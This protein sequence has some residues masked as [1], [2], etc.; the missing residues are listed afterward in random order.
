MRPISPNFTIA[1]DPRLLFPVSLPGSSTDTPNNR[2]SFEQD[3]TGSQTHPTVT[4]VAGN[5]HFEQH[6]KVQVDRQQSNEPDDVVVNSLKQRLVDTSLAR[7]SLRIKNTQLR[8]S[9]LSKQ[10]KLEK[11]IKDLKNCN[12]ELITKLNESQHQNEILGQ[13]HAQMERT[14]HLK[15]SELEE[16]LEVQLGRE[17]EDDVKILKKQLVSASLA[18]DSFRVKN[19]LLKK[20]SIRKQQNHHQEMDD[21]KRSHNELAS[22]LNQAKLENEIMG[23]KKSQMERDNEIKISELEEKCLRLENEKEDLAVKLIEAV[24]E[25]KSVSSSFENQKET[26]LNLEKKILDLESTKTRGPNVAYSQ[27]TQTNAPTVLSCLPKTYDRDFLMQRKSFGIKKPQCL[28]VEIVRKVTM[29]TS[30]SKITEPLPPRRQIKLF[31][32]K[33]SERVVD[34]SKVWQPRRATPVAAT[35]TSA[36]DV[37]LNTVRGILNKMTPASHKR[38]LAKIL[39]L[40]INNEEKLSGVIKL[41]FEKALDEPMYAATYAKMCQALATKHVVSSTNPTE[42]VSFRKLLLS[43]CQKV[44]QKDSDSLVDVEKKREVEKADTKEKKKILQTELIALVDKNRRTALGNIKFIGEL[45][46]VGNISENV[47]H[48][49]IRRLLQAPD[50]EAT[51]SLCRLLTAI[52]KGLENHKNIGIMNSYFQALDSIIKQSN[53]SNRIRF[54]VQDVCDLRKRKWTPRNEPCSNTNTV[55]NRKSKSA[56]EPVASTLQITKSATKEFG[57]ESKK[58]PSKKRYL[59]DEKDRKELYPWSLLQE[60]RLNQRSQI[61]PWIQLS[62]RQSYN[63]EKPD[64]VEGLQI[65][66]KFRLKPAGDPQ[67]LHP[68]PGKIDL[69]EKKDNQPQRIPENT[70]AWLQNQEK[71]DLL[72]K[73][74]NLPRHK[75]EEKN[76]LPPNPEN[77]DLMGKKENDLIKHKKISIKDDQEELSRALLKPDSQRQQTVSEK[78]KE[79]QEKNFHAKLKQSIKNMK[80]SLLSPKGLLQQ[81]KQVAPESKK[82]PSIDKCVINGDTFAL[83]RFDGELQI[84]MVNYSFYESIGKPQIVQTKFIIKE[85]KG[86]SLPILG[87]IAVKIVVNDEERMIPI[88][89]VNNPSET[90]ASKALFIGNSDLPIKGV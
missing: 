22:E 86:K 63:P 10:Q 20:S 4:S 75:S 59:S 87:E 19:N 65:D 24:T 61:T 83:C 39:A 82:N 46:K 51:E 53:I 57:F 34:T 42:S 77:Y 73:K 41:F 62:F 36:T 64:L 74:D 9:S 17:R 44:F 68:N 84:A 12:D 33:P 7:D 47:M 60:V 71:S 23:H 69:F 67:V 16:H 76:A 18:R 40:E 28:P 48:N 50:E 11:E 70:H 13:Q 80:K 21:L 1:A 15:I 2:V 30:S 81:P 38:F 31:D 29:G 6:L 72:E 8:K 32:M 78:P 5:L 54:M 26:I 88:L 58:L 27:G 52:G 79:E 3:P 56:D 85:K 37:L 45:Y 49:C 43:R 25:L 90:N 89:V 35:V 66:N 55:E 14:C